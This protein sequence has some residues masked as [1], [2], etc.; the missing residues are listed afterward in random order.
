MLTGKGSITLRTI[1]T[2]SVGEHTVK[3]V[4]GVFAALQLSEL[5]HKV[6]CPPMKS[7]EADNMF[8]FDQQIHIF[9]I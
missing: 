3:L 1:L 5:Y 7:S 9:S 4:G 2:P 8:Q 6:C